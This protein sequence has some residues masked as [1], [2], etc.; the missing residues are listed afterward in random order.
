[1][2]GMSL[3]E[4]RIQSFYL[5]II[6]ILLSDSS[7]NFLGEAN[8]EK[9]TSDFEQE[10]NQPFSGFSNYKLKAMNVGDYVLGTPLYQPTNLYTCTLAFII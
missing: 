8:V 6:I 1:M 5:L 9:D 10:G 4:V 2:L 3:T 7:A